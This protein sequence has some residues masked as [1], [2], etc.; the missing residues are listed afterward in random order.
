MCFSLGIGVDIISKNT[1]MLLN[2]LYLIYKAAT[3][4][5]N[6]KTALFTQNI[7]I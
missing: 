2:E 4:V 6:I 5:R 3:K 7:C 1:A